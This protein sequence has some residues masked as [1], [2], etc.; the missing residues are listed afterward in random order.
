MKTNHSLHNINGSIRRCMNSSAQ[1]KVVHSYREGNACA[2]ALAKMA[3]NKPV[4]VQFLCN[5]PSA[6]LRILEADYC[7][8]A[9]PRFC[10][11]PGLFCYRLLF[12]LLRLFPCITKKKEIIKIILMH[13]NSINYLG[14]S[15]VIDLI[16][17]LY[18]NILGASEHYANS[19]VE[20]VCE[21]NSEK[22][23]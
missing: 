5:P 11:C 12:G 7:G 20:K 1:V 22:C 17:L 19:V 3:L 6:I 18:L 9:L 21:I 8:V 13:F 4:G 15:R 2:D 10:P 23:M 16:I 14:K